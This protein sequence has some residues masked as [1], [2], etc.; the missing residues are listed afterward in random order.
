MDFPW[1][2]WG[3][4][5]KPFQNGLRI[6]FG[7]VWDS[8]FPFGEERWLVFTQV[9]GFRLDPDISTDMQ[10]G[11]DGLLVKMGFQCGKP[12]KNTTMTGD[13]LY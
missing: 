3:N 9:W 13:G 6:R 5:G 12:N 2:C 8:F 7:M 11:W 1:K 4:M 10:M